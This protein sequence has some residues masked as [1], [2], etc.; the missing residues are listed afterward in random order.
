MIGMVSLQ[1]IIDAM[2]FGTDEFHSYLNK[3]TGEI[4]TIRGFLHIPS[5]RFNPN[6]A[7]DFSR[8]GSATK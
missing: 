1:D 3:K 5:K 2:D 8:H 7:L 4:I 6:V